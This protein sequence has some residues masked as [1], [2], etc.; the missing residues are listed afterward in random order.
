MAGYMF[1][2]VLHEYRQQA[3]AITWITGLITIAALLVL[4]IWDAPSS[5]GWAAYWACILIL[6]RLVPFFWLAYYTWRQPAA[7]CGRLL[8]L[9]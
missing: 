5:A 6:F 1:L 3:K 8:Q 9:P 2:L 7:P 4:K